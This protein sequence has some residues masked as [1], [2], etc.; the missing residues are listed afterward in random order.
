MLQGYKKYGDDTSPID[1][2]VKLSGKQ[3]TEAKQE[4]L[5]KMFKLEKKLKTSNMVLFQKDNSLKLYRTP[6]ESTI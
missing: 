5:E 6:Q 1:I 2:R 3:L 4:G